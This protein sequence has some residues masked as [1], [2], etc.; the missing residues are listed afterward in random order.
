MIKCIALRVC[1]LRIGVGHKHAHGPYAL[2]L[3][4]QE[5]VHLVAITSPV[6]RLQLNVEAQL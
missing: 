4:A 5:F 1:N 2:G 6:S 3:L